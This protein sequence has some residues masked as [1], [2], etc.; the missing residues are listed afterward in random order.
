MAY[1]QGAGPTDRRVR[2]CL[3]RGAGIGRPRSNYILE[4]GGVQMR[5][6]TVLVVLLAV[7]GPSLTCAAGEGGDPGYADIAVAE[8]RELL[9]SD[10][11]DTVLILDVRQPDEY[12]EGHIEG[13][14]LIPLGELASR[15]DEIDRTRTILVVCWSGFRSSRAAAALIEAGYAQVLNLR[16]GMA[17]WDGPVVTGAQSH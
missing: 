16:G 6:Q 10:R 9:A 7:L 1:S 4:S 11:R 5:F 3:D 15:L 14:V 8:A 13:A 17:S 12:E 2:I